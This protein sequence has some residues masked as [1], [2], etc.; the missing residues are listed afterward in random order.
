MKKTFSMLI[1]VLALGAALQTAT[2]QNQERNS[3]LQNSSARI[4]LQKAAEFDGRAAFGENIGKM[5]AE[6]YYWKD[7][8]YL[9]M[10]DG[11]RLYTAVYW[12]KDT[13]RKHPILVCRT[14][15]SCAP[16]GRDYTDEF[17][18][19]HLG[20]YL[21]E[22]YIIVFQ[23]VRG[24]YRSQG[25]FMHI[26]PMLD[27]ADAARSSEAA[28]AIY[29]GTGKRSKNIPT[30]ES[31]DSYDTVDWLIHNIRCNNGK[32]GFTGNSYPG[33]YAMLAGLC[34]HPAIKA[35]AP[36]APVTDWFMGDDV[37]HNGAFCMADA[38]GFV[39]WLDVYMMPTTKY[40]STPRLI[41][42]GTSPYD[43]Y[44]EK[45]C[46]DSLTTM[47]GLQYGSYFW[48]DI[49]QHPDYDEFWKARDTRRH[50]Y[51][52]KPAV[53]VTGGEYDGEDLYGAI[54]LYK[55]IC[56]QSPSTDCRLAFGPWRHG[57]WLGRPIP[58]YDMDPTYDYFFDM[59]LPFFNY[60]LKGE[61][62][63]ES[64]PKALVFDTGL[65]AWRNYDSEPE[66]FASGAFEAT[67]DGAS[68]RAGRSSGRGSE[69]VLSLEEG[70]SL[71]LDERSEMEGGVKSGIGSGMVAEYVSDPKN[72]VPSDGPNPHGK[73]Y[74]YD[75]Q[76]FLTSR[77]DVAAFTSTAL[78]ENV[79][80]SG[81]VRVALNVSASTT[82]ADFVVKLIDVDTTGYQLMVRGDIMPARF[83][84]GFEK[85]EP[86]VPNEKAKVT[87][88]MPDICHTFL[89]GHKIMVV[90]QSSWF[91]LFAM[92][93]Q[94]FVENFYRCNTDDYVKSTIK[95]LSGS[96]LTVPEGR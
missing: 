37:H 92:N 85:P 69:L 40:P 32:V 46:I 30:D 11:A 51:N 95:V 7:E 35:V 73:S 56:A 47:L 87:F 12:P 81:P 16:Y 59:E 34:G 61:G 68:A 33:F 70:N 20:T 15:Y 63:L 84:N 24:R 9:T 3:N 19:H 26:R 72:P 44:L 4:D 78:T 94:N 76:S 83:R 42:K 31:T 8:Y 39:P 6:K 62:S 25:R 93:P 58:L 1:A 52:V 21:E 10:R 91:P 17:N 18:S 36:Q 54:N 86:L 77:A 38:F 80:V 50:C 65:N 49:C 27:A 53:L 96:T 22:G 23:D 88:V 82:D 14:P 67:A 41:P 29:A 89:P 74:M 79:S 43:F 28:A 45:G 66:E 55:A 5:F 75:D 60:Y 90:V 2:A 48:Q 13:V 71:A 64:L 57:S